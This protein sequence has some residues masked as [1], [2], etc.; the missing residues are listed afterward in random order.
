MKRLA[1]IIFFTVSLIQIKVAGN[2]SVSEP[3]PAADSLP[4]VLVPNHADLVES[5]LR[6][7]AR[8]K[9]AEHRLPDNPAD[10][11]AYRI[12]LKNEII[13]K[14]GIR[15]DHGL[16]LNVKETGSIRMKGY[17]IKNITFQTRPGIYATANLYIPDG[18]GPFPGVINMLGHWTKGKIDPTGPQGVGHTLALN[19]YVCLTIDP[20][21]A[22]ERSTRHGEFEYHGANLG[23]S[24]M[25]IGETLLGIQVSDNMRGVDLLCSLP[26]V[27]RDKIGATGASGGGNQTMW[28]AAMDERVKAAVPVVSVGSFE[29]YIMRS[30]CICELLIDGLTFTEEA[31]VLALANA[32]MPSNHQKDSNPTFFPS[33]MLRTYNNALKVFKMM[34]KEENISYRIFDLT[35]GY[36]AQDREAML[37]WFDLQLKGTGDGQ[38]KKEIPFEQLPEEKLMVFSK[39]HRDANVISTDEYCRERGNVLRSDFLSS[40]SFDEE[41]KKHEL[42]AIVR[43]KDKTDLKKAY[44]Y[45]SLNGWDRLA[46][47]TTD[48]KLIPLLH[49]A[50]SNASAG[51]VVICNP[52]GKQSISLSLIDEWKKKGTGI[53]IAD[54]TGT[55]ETASPYDWPKNNKSM[56]LHTLARAEIWLGKTIMGEWI[57]DY[58]L[59]ARYLKSEYKA[60]KIIIDGSKEAGLAGLFYGALEGIVDEIILRDAPVSYLFDNRDSVDFFSMAIHLPGFLNW[61]DVS[62]AAALSGKDVTFVNPVSMSGQKLSQDKLKSFQ[63]EFDTIRNICRKPGKTVFIN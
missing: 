1:L 25:N 61:G 26:Y 8:L 52:G 33:E 39:G 51:Y 12:K 57:K 22:G 32:I 11:E 40:K 63:T 38:P 44:K 49:M 18:Q 58:Y 14:A 29:S 56:I 35:H 13:S 62:L 15:I 47:E 31:G 34:G 16:P 53:V 2:P 20:W 21:G 42:H 3:A 46:I 59:I 9:F 48:N 50:P 23:A 41:K 4:V 19:K 60:E 28:F 45:T 17:T 24:L 37:G 5:K 43:L 30:N 7:E 54:L 36:M 55:G 6:H 10:W 27:D